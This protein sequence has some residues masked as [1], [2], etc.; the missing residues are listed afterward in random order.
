MNNWTGIYMVLIMLIL[1]GCQPVDS[2]APIVLTE[3]PQPSAPPTL[4]VPNITGLAYYVSIETNTAFERASDSVGKPAPNFTFEQDGREYQLSDWRGTSVF[5]VFWYDMCPPCHRY[6][7]TLLTM[8]FSS[9]IPILIIGVPIE[10]R[11][12]EQLVRVIDDFNVTWPVIFDSANEL[13]NEYKTTGYP[14]TFLLDADGIIVYE[15]L[16]DLPAAGVEEA[17]ALLDD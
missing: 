15:H 11:A 12:E 9:D 1:V 10:D 6:L 16:G 17:L 7:L 2:E 14:Y 5:I 3:I 4:S 8:P 13:H